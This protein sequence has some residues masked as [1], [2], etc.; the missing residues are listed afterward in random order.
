MTSDTGLEQ[1]DAIAAAV[2]RFVRGEIFS[3]EHDKRL[4]PH[5]PS[6]DLV[7]ELRAIRVHLA[8]HEIAGL[9]AK[10]ERLRDVGGELHGREDRIRARLRALMPALAGEGLDARRFALLARRARRAEAAIELTVD[11]AAAALSDRQWPAHGPIGFAAAVHSF[12]SGRGMSACSPEPSAWNCSSYSPTMVTTSASRM[13]N[14]ALRPEL[15]FEI[16][17]PKVAGFLTVLPPQ[18]FWT[19]CARVNDRFPAPLS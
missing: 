9:Q 3:Y 16:S 6:E 12:R 13:A 11:A 17:R 10:G 5:G 2:E 14:S 1:A 8:G 4:G 15:Q 18:A 19:S 7:E